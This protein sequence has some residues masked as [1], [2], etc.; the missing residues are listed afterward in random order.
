[1]CY[2]LNGHIVVFTVPSLKPLLDVDVVPWPNVRSVVLLHDDF[3]V[4][5]VICCYIYIIY[6][7]F[8]I[9]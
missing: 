3:I 5:V 6:Y 9:T 8:F 7:I 4:I 1:M 2:L